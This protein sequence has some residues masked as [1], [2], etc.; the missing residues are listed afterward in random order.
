MKSSSAII[1]WINFAIVSHSPKHPVWCFLLHSRTKVRQFLDLL[2]LFFGKRC[3]WDFCSEKEASEDIWGRK[4]IC[5]TSGGEQTVAWSVVLGLLGV[6][7]LCY[8]WG[9]GEL[10]KQSLLFS[11]GSGF[12]NSKGKA[13]RNWR[14]KVWKRFHSKFQKSLNHFNQTIWEA[15]ALW[16]VPWSRSGDNFELYGMTPK[17]YK[18]NEN[19]NQNCMILSTA[20]K[21]CKDYPL[22]SRACCRTCVYIWD[23]VTNVVDTSQNMAW[24]DVQSRGFISHIFKHQ[25]S[26]RCDQI[27]I[28]LYNRFKA[29]KA[30]GVELRDGIRI[31]LL[32]WYIYPL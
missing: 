16:L 15:N 2:Q 23:C 8:D 4:W 12:K 26:I 19:C 5:I 28:K 1:E 22:K 29:F 20:M 9:N 10:S 17:S 30:R 32:A 21:Y 31:L 25:A 3:V 11:P 27:L 14:W 13:R 6:D 7:S 24:E 18:C